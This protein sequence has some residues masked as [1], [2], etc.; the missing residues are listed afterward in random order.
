MAGLHKQT[1]C[2]R[3][4]TPGGHGKCQGPTRRCA[5]TAVGERGAHFRPAG[6]ARVASRKRENGHVRALPTQHASCRE[7]VGAAGPTCST[8]RRFPRALGA[9]RGCHPGPGAAPP[10]PRRLWWTGSPPAL[11]WRTPHLRF[12]PLILSQRRWGW[13]HPPPVP[14]RRRHLLQ[15]EGTPRGIHASRGSRPARGYAQQGGDTHAGKGK[16]ETGVCEHGGPRPAWSPTCCASGC[17]W[18]RHGRGG[19][20]CCTTRHVAGRHHL[21]HHDTVHHECLGCAAHSKQYGY[22]GKAHG[23]VPCHLCVLNGRVTRHQQAAL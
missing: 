22:R 1:T 9:P 14:H 6:H 8:H 16:R 23:N 13:R 21:A 15:Q 3:A 19:W 11:T 4:S 10:S 17:A 20:R 5:T 12:R 18:C 2:G 7:R